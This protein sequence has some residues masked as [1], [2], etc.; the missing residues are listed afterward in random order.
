MTLVNVPS[1]PPTQDELVTT[2]ANG[3]REKL[4]EVVSLAEIRLTEIRNIVRDKTRAAIAAELGADAADLLSVYNSL[5]DAVETAKDT[6]ID[7]LP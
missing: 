3:C 1:T 6:S 2:A 5:K 4:D 7:S